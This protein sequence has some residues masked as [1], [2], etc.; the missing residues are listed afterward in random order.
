MQGCKYLTVR[1]D[2]T[3][4]PWWGFTM[5]PTDPAAPAG[6][7]AYAAA[8]RELKMDPEY[9]DSI[10]QLAAEWE[11]MKQPGGDPDAGP[12]R[13]DD[14]DVI[15]AMMRPGCKVTVKVQYDEPA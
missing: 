15:A 4:P 5:A 13:K 2:G 9:C 8:C 11:E 12:H 1:R 3:T 6:L 7:K 14:P 10:L